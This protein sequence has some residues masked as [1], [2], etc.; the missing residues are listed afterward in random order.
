MSWF[1]I[2]SRKK[3][4]KAM[5][6]AI[7]IAKGEEKS[8]T[9]ALRVIKHFEKVNHIIFDPFN[10]SHLNRVRNHAADEKFF[11]NAKRIF[12]RLTNGKNN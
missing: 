8:I 11:R 7:N 12:R 1:K 2:D 6:N 10:Q 4:R 3:Y 5:R 9:D